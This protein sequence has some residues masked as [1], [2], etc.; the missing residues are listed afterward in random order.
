MA[1]YQNVRVPLGD[2]IVRARTERGISRSKLAEMTGISEN[3]L[4]KYEKAGVEPDGQFPPSPKLSAIC[5]VL[6]ITPVEALLGCLEGDE[7]EQYYYESTQ[8]WVEGHPGYK[9]AMREIRD[10]AFENRLLVEAVRVI[11]FPNSSDQHDEETIEWAKDEV[12][13][14]MIKRGKL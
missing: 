2:L 8:K 4:V 1:S 11:L 5:A 10:L 3:S 13:K 6:L 14:L 7:W 9:L 12:R